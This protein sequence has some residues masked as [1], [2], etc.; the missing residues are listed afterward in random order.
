MLKSSSIADFSIN[1]ILF[2][3]A[4]LTFKKSDRIINTD[5]KNRNKKTK[6]LIKYSVIYLIFLPFYRFGRIFSILYW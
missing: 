2:Y 3:F 4:V 6:V 1:F 5:F